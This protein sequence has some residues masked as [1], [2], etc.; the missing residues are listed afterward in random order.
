MTHKFKVPI[1]H[2][3]GLWTCE[4]RFTLRKQRPNWYLS[5]CI[6]YIFFSEH[7]GLAFIH[8]SLGL[9]SSDLW[10]SYNQSKGQQIMIMPHTFI[11][12]NIP[13]NENIL[14]VFRRGSLQICGPPQ[15]TR[16]I[17]IGN[18]LQ[19]SPDSTSDFAS[20][21]PGQPG[22]QSPTMATDSISLLDFLKNRF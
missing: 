11:T 16:T 17:A 8:M 6:H 10:H 1:G 20:K 18:F 15:A 22:V 9:T 14:P 12:T 13:I 4:R 3:T 21:L 19:N 5:I 7:K 2:I